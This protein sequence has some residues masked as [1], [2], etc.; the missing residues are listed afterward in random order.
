MPATREDL[1]QFHQFA[2]EQINQSDL[3]LEFD[4]LVTNWRELRERLEVKAIL[5]QA[6]AE[7][8]AGLGRPASEV[9]EELRV[10]YNISAS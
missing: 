8:D 3:P 7:M 9:M 1:E 10:K 6:L 2:M 5:E 4:D